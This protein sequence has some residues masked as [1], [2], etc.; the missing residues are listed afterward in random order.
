MLDA[1][2]DHTLQDGDGVFGHQ[3]LECHQER[4]L[5]G[6]RALDGGPAAPESV[7][8]HRQANEISTTYMR[9]SFR[10]IANHKT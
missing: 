4:S 5:Q 9:E 1:D 3:L 10:E 6:N 8:P 2:L 7:S